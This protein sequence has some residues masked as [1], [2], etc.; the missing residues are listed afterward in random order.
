MSSNDELVV[1][2]VSRLYRTEK[3]L[4]RPA[5]FFTAVDDVSFALAPGDTLGL[6][7]ESGSG[8]S[9]LG[10]IAAGIDRQSSGSVR[11]RGEAYARIGSADWR[12]QRQGVQFVFQ[13]P[14]GAVDPRLTIYDQVAEALDAHEKLARSE[15]DRRITEM[16]DL[17]GLA[18]L[19]Q[20][21]PQQLSGG[22]LQ[23]AIIARAL[24]MRPRLLICDEA[25]SALDVSVQA[26]IINLLV[27]LREQLGLSMIFITHDLSVARH[28]GRNVAVMHR[29]RVVEMNDAATLFAAPQH[30]YT[31]KLLAAIP[32]SSPAAR[33][34]RDAAQSKAASTEVLA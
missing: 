25:V 2:N 23:R 22:Q 20:R 27:S 30:D 14:A 32:A 28:I 21:V 8:K 31:R 5:K 24:V 11:F 26:Q 6:V 3:R 16:L 34:A 4:F 13:N 15:R 10:R 18:S 1:T 17:V 33:R 19:A 7:G 12:R 29:G 9:T